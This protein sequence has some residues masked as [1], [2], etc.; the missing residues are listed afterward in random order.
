MWALLI[1]VNITISYLSEWFWERSPPLAF[2]NLGGLVITLLSLLFVK[3]EKNDSTMDRDSDPINRADSASEID[4][5][6]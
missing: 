5:E 3:N 2:F 4:S 6:S 1:V